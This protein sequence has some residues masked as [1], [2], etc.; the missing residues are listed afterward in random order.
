MNYKE[1]KEALLSKGFT[2]EYTQ[3]SG[4]LDMLQFEHPTIEGQITVD[5]DYNYKLPQNIIDGEEFNYLESEFLNDIP[6]KSIEFDK[7]LGI[8]YLSDGVIDTCGVENENKINLF[9]DDIDKHFYKVLSFLDTPNNVIEFQK[10]YNEK[11]LKFNAQIKKY[12]PIIAKFGMVYGLFSN[13]G[14]N[15][16]T[17][18][19]NFCFYF[20]YNKSKYDTISFDFD[21]FNEEKNRLVINICSETF[22]GD[23]NTPLDVFETKLSEIINIYNKVRVAQEK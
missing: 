17:V 23:L 18:F 7:N 5:F 16:S 20:K 1:I 14:G 4:N 6:I 21:L 13:Y 10:E 22:F 15:E 11:V 8:S 12:F 3:T 9:N 19:R 2:L